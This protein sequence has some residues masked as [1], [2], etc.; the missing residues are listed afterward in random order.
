MVKH[1]LHM[2]TRC[3]VLYVHWGVEGGGESKQFHCHITRAERKWDAVILVK[4]T[5][6]ATP[7]CVM[8]KLMMKGSRPVHA[9]V[10]GL[11]CNKTRKTGIQW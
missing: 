8:V 9:S 1:I 4:L 10:V 5:Y 7:V 2:S 6:L 11:S 3:Q